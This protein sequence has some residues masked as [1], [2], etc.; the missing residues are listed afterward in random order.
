MSFCCS[1]SQKNRPFGESHDRE[2]Y[3][4]RI[5]EKKTADVLDLGWTNECSLTRSNT[6]PRPNPARIRRE[7]RPAMGWIWAELVSPVC[8]SS[9]GQSNTVWYG[10]QA[11]AQVHPFE[12]V[13]TLSLFIT[14]YLSISINFCALPELFGKLKRFH[15]SNNWRVFFSPADE[16]IPLEWSPLVDVY[17]EGRCS[18][19]WATSELAQTKMI[20]FLHETH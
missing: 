15:K 12:K 8:L 9:W 16:G 7:L 14:W 5:E 1:Y 11:L 18:T 2:I 13:T 20:D 6:V 3:Q 17:V 4:A 19:T 10:L